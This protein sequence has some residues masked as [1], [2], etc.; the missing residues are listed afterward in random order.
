MQDATGGMG[1]RTL[2]RQAQGQ[3]RVRRGRP[4]PPKRR[5]RA[6]LG[7]LRRH[8]QR[9]RVQK[10]LNPHI[11]AIYGDSIN[12]DRADQICAC[13]AEKGFASANVVL[14]VGSFT[15]QYVTRDTSGFAMKAT[16]AEV[17][18]VGQ[19]LFKDPITDDGLKRSARGRLAINRDGD[20][21]LVMIYQAD[22]T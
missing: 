10:E 20:G 8:H 14:G 4:P 21:E 5:H 12:Y 6:A 13:L 11:G 22:A 15:Y 3:P 1:R 7:R 9:C 19:D 17:D 18:G 16:W 2:P